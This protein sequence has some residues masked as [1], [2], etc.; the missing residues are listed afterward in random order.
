MGRNCRFL[1]G[2]GTNPEDVQRLR[3]GIAAGG[4]VTVCFCPSLCCSPVSLLGFYSGHAE[5]VSWAFLEGVCR[6]PCALLSFYISSEG[7]FLGDAWPLGARDNICMYARMDMCRWALTWALHAGEAAEL[8][9]RWHA[10]LESSSCDLCPE[11]LREGGHNFLP[12]LI[13][14]PLPLVALY[15]L[16]SFLQHALDGCD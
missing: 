2:P 8:Q 15:L 1:Q 14:M 10:L 12:S 6:R 13:V 4:P 16:C 11:R 5:M 7:P 9:V 3:D